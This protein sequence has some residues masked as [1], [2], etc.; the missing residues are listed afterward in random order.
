[1]S[2]T[3]QESVALTV[4]LRGCW[5]PAWVQVFLSFRDFH[6]FVQLAE[7]AL[8]HLGLARG[9]SFQIHAHSS[10]LTLV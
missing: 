3:K 6:P 7:G 1:V 2:F 9:H 4:G 10:F 8:S 5:F